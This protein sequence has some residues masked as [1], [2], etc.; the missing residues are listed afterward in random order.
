MLLVLYNKYVI[1]FPVLTIECYSC[2]YEEA[3]FLGIE[4]ASGTKLCEDDP[5][6][7]SGRETCTGMCAVSNVLM[8]VRSE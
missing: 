2:E 8:H 1:I 3:E 4:S 6:A 5:T 7:V